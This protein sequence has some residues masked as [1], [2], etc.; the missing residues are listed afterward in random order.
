MSLFGADYIYPASVSDYLG[1][2]VVQ[3]LGISG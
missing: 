2:N 1:K 3:P